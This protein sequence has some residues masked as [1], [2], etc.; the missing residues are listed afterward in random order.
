MWMADWLF[1]SSINWTGVSEK[2]QS[3]E[4]EYVEVMLDFE[5][6]VC[7]KQT[8]PL[9]ALTAVIFIPGLNFEFILSKFV[10]LN[11][12]FKPNL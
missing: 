3:V 2:N 10:F 5:I 4:T 8:F 11:C 12:I 7:D 1:V 6:S 9:E